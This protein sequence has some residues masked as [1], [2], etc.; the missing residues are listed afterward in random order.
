MQLPVMVATERNSEFIA[1]FET[2]SSGLGKAQV[3]RIGRLTAAD[4]TG[5][6]SD[7]PQMGLVTKP[8]GFGDRQG[9][10]CRFCPAAGRVRPGQSRCRLT[11]GGPV[12]VFPEPDPASPDPGG[13]H[14]SGTAADRGGVVRRKP[15][16]PVLLIKVASTRALNLSG[17]MQSSRSIKRQ[18][19]RLSECGKRPF[20]GIGFRG[21]ERDVV[22]F[23]R[24]CATP[25]ARAVAFPDDGCAIGVHGNAHP[26]D[27]DGEE[28]SRGCHGLGT[29]LD[30]T[31]SVPAI[32]PEDPVGFRDRVPTFDIGEFATMGLARADMRLSRSRRSACTCFAEKPITVSSRSKPAPGRRA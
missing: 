18:S 4:E 9:R 5:L 13:G 24:R 15:D 22:H 7:K 20:G 27:I 14:S 8:L 19:E 6:R 21:L 30:S 1:D 11:A 32:K 29:H 23:A 25:F 26:G 31:V 12:V 2:Q 28:C 17:E 3:M 10:S 16:L